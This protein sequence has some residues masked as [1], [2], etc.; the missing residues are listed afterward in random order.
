[1]NNRVTTLSDLY[2]KHQGKIC[3][4]WSLYLRVYEDL[5]GSKRATTRNLLEIGIQNGGSLELWAQY[6]PNA[7]HI[8]G[9]D[10][11][12]DCGTLFFDDPRISVIVGDANADPA[13]ENV[14]TI[15]QNFD[16]IIDDGSHV[17]RD[18]IASFVNYFQLLSPGGT[19]V[20]EDVHCDYLDSHAGGILQPCTS[21][22]FFHCLVHL[23]HQAHWSAELAPETFA[24][25]FIP[26][27]R[28]PLFLKHGWIDS[29]T[30][31]DS[32]IVVRRAD[33]EESGAL[34]RRIIVGEIATVS[35][36]PILLRDLLESQE[37]DRQ[38]SGS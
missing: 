3:D 32:M 10:I 6:L 22:N 34:G 37:R 20:V 29:I 26:R 35:T 15:C 2:A 18:V 14:K 9:C 7:Q 28:F 38:R 4:K 19:Y 11:N 12:P 25:G 16:V 21:N 31:F 1:V 30:F 24:A 5:F 8:V 13:F 33:S 27:E 23:M 36:E 17:P